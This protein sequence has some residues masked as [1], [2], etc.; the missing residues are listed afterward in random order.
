MAFINWNKSEITA[1]ELYNIRENDF[2]GLLLDS[3]TAH[4][5]INDDD[6]ETGVIVFDAL[7]IENQLFER[8]ANVFQKL[9]KGK[10]QAVDVA[11]YQVTEPF[12]RNGTLNRAIIFELDD[13]QTVSVYLHNPDVTDKTVQPTL[14]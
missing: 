4:D 5:I 14:S 2:N 1:Q 9:M 8:K 6:N 11:S 7:I 3:I 10:S 12:K 13:G